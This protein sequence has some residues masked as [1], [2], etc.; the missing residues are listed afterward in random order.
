MPALFH[1]LDW[2][3]GHRRNEGKNQSASRDERRKPRRKNQREGIERP[4]RRMV[5]INVVDRRTVLV[6]ANRRDAIEMRVDQRGMI[7]IRSGVYVLKR[8]QQE[9]QRKSQAGQQSSETPHPKQVYTANVKTI[10]A[11]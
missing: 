1:Q 9:S 2:L 8:C 11:S 4:G 7:V 6:P 10:P 3:E 5:V